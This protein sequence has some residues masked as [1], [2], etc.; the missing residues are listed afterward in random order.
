[1]HLFMGAEE[2][3]KTEVKKPELTAQQKADVF[4]TVFKGIADSTASILKVFNPSSPS[5]N[6][7]NAPYAATTQPST[8]VVK[9][10]LDT[11][12]LLIPATIAGLGLIYLLGKK[13]R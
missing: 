7:P 9:Q 3:P 11:E 6:Q 13:K 2:K 4:S 12:K 1:M 8:T 10:G 5:Q